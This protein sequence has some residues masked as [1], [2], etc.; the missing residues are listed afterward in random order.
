[1]FAGVSCPWTGADDAQQVSQ[2]IPQIDRPEVF[3]VAPNNKELIMNIDKQQ[4]WLTSFTQLQERESS[5]K[6]R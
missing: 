4:I 1:M 5:M 2:L 6:K 3:F